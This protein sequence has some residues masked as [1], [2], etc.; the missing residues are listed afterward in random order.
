VS[1]GSRASQRALRQRAH[2]HDRLPR[3]PRPERGRQSLPSNDPAPCCARAET[4]TP[5]PFTASHSTTPPHTNSATGDITGDGLPDLLAIAGD[6]PWAFTGYTGGTFAQ[7]HL[8]YG[9]C[10]WDTRDIITVGDISGDGIAD[11]VFRLQGSKR[12][13]L[14]EGTDNGSG[15]ADPDS[16]GRGTTDTEYATGWGTTSFPLVMGTPDLNGDG[17][18][19]IW[20]RYLDGSIR[21]YFATRTSAGN[22]TTVVQRGWE[23]R[24]AFG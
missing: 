20:T 16:L 1:Q 15:G 21:V 24:L 9:G 11:L 13:I 4:R 22:Y 10:S 6:D 23:S 14:R 3:R 7:A 18:P 12:L 17:I 5:R 19:D 8:L 2:R